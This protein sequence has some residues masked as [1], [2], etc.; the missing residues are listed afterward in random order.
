MGRFG[1]DAIDGRCKAAEALLC[2]SALIR[3]TDPR[4]EITPTLERLQIIATGWIGATS[5]GNSSGLIASGS[6]CDPQCEIRYG[7]R[8]ICLRGLTL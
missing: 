2:G 1:V 4:V 5:V 6:D 7:K 3:S 8:L